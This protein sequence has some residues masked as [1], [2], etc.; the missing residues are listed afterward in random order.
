M[1]FS[2]LKKRTPIFWRRLGN[3]AIYSLPLATTA[4]MASPLGSDTR[5]WITFGLTIILVAA[6]AV[7]KFFAEPDNQTLK[8]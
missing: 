4:V 1:K 7:S 5:Q 6:K 8:N 3:T 2:N